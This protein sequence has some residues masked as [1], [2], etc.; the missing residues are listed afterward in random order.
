MESS[1]SSASPPRGHR[2]INPSQ[3][4]TDRIYRAIRH[5]LRLLH[6]VGA[7]FFVLGATGNVYTV[8]LCTAPSCTCPDRTKP[9]KHILFVL[10]KAL[11]LPPDAPCL[12]RRT[13]RPCQLSNLLAA[14]TLAESLASAS[15]Q[16]RFHELF[17]QSRPT[18][19]SGSGL[20]REFV[21]GAMCPV[22]LEEMEAGEKAERCGT[23]RNWIHE[24]CLVRWRRSRGRR[25]A[26]CVVC[27]AKWD[28]AE[29]DKRLY[30]NL[31]A[32]AAEE[33]GAA[34][35][36]ESGSNSRCGDVSS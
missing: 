18:L 24:E 11:G 25:S 5:R 6:R 19:P 9:C 20:V 28:G 29:K 23:C 12:R 34:S 14:P 32:Y 3:P 36:Q 2:P 13:L 33:D 27:R 22:C 30:L 17:N 10:I 16:N 8:T 7:S 35:P 15:V 21:E 4:I 26:N 1:A 31:A